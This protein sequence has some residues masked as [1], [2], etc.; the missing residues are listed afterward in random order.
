MHDTLGLLILSILSCLFLRD[1]WGEMTRKQ[2]LTYQA[3][4]WV[5]A[6]ITLYA[7]YAIWSAMALGAALSFPSTPNEKRSVSPPPIT[8]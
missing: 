1:R 7:D 3:I 4:L 6:A 5:I 8:D 2:V